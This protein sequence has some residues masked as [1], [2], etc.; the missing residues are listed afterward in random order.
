MGLQDVQSSFGKVIVGLMF[1]DLPEERL[2]FPT[3][4]LFVIKLFSGL[5]VKEFFGLLSKRCLL[6]KYL[7]NIC[8]Q[9]TKS[10]DYT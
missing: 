1:I 7:N 8:R 5:L 9:A 6:G 2:P 3:S 10:F 4:D